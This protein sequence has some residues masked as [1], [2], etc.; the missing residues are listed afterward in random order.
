MSDTR[1]CT[2]D[3]CPIRDQCHRQQV[4]TDPHG[5]QWKHWTPYQVRNGSWHCEGWVP[6]WGVRDE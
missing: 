4:E 1:K 3:K 6:D 2:N 5:Q